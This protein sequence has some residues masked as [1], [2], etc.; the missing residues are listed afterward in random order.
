MVVYP[1]TPQSQ[2]TDVMVPGAD[3]TIDHIILSLD[4][5]A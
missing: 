3:H 4:S 2:V 5:L 1:Y